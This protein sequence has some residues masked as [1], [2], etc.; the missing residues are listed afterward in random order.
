MRDSITVIAIVAWVAAGRAVIVMLGSLILLWTGAVKLTGA[1]VDQGVKF[2][3]MKTWRVETRNPALGL[4]AVGIL[5][6]CVA[7]W[8]AQSQNVPSMRVT[9]KLVPHP[10]DIP[11]ALFE[12][13]DLLAKSS[14]DTSGEILEPVY[15]LFNNITR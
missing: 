8:C 3:F 15:D 11:I 14:I 2:E 12:N 5:C 1:E 4:F 7:V 13:Q 9:A 6:L 10:A